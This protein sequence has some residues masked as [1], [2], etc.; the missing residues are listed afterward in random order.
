MVTPTQGGARKETWYFTKPYPN[1]EVYYPGTEE[2]GPDQMRVSTQASSSR[3]DPGNSY[4][5]LAANK[6]R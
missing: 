6:R 2:L 4:N 3:S 1:Q 5:L